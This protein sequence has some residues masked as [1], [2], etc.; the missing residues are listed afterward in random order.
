MK[1]S[2]LHLKF[3]NYEAAS[4]DLEKV[5][6]R[7]LAEGKRAM[8]EKIFKASELYATA[9]KDYAAS[10]WRAVESH[11]R[12]L[13]ADYSP[14]A[15]EVYDMRIKALISLKEWQR[16]IDSARSKA[17]V[18]SDSSETNLLIGKI[19]LSMGNLATGRKFVT[20]CA[21]LNP[22]NRKCLALRNKFK[23]FEAAMEEAEKRMLLKDA[24]AA[25]E[26]LLQQVDKTPEDE[27]YYDENF[28]NLFEGY[29]VQV[30]KLLCAKYARRK[31]VDR[32]LEVCG[33][34]R[35]LDSLNQE[36]YLL[37]LGELYLSQDK[38]DE[39][40]NYIQQAQRINPRDREVRELL[41]KAQKQKQEK[42]RTKYY[43]LLGVP[44]DAS[45]DQI[46]KAYNFLVRKWHPDKQPNEDSRRQA[47]EKMHDI[48]A[49]YE[50]LSDKKKRAQYDQGFDPNDPQGASGFSSGGFGGFGGGGGGFGGVQFDIN[51]FAQFF[52]QARGHRGG[53][54]GGGGRGRSNR[55]SSH[56]HHHHFYQDDL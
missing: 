23:S 1:L 36:Y 3:G 41:Q 29:R 56:H 14:Y 48:N 10:S 27:P 7:D 8:R 55:G 9:K 15:K 16:A 50:V 39:A 12:D 46:K 32:A 40:I 44:R 28:P 6:D 26:A 21:K 38:H 54:G 4:R 34:A 18:E 47:Q 53:G 43:D 37:R 17:R 45:D 20:E 33:K 2:G 31:Q 25:L 19:Y 5:V 22:E 11:C 49:A 35:T 42:A 52:Q 13:I 24:V 30:L 51:D